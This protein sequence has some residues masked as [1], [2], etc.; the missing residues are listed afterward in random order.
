VAPAKNRSKGSEAPGKRARK[1]MRRYADPRQ[2][3]KQGAADVERGVKDTSRGR[4]NLP[5]PPAK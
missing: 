1:T 3:V 2:L 4:D 5:K